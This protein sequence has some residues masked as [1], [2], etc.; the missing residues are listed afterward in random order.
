[1]SLFQYQGF[2]MPMW[3]YRNASEVS[4][5]VSKMLATNSNAGIIDFHL[6]TTGQTGN[7]V[8][9][10][11]DNTLAQLDTAIKAAKS[12]GLDVWFKPIVIMGTGAD[13]NSWQTLAPTDPA[14]WFRTYTAKLVEIGKVLQADGVSHFLLTNEL[15]SMTTNPAYAGYWGALITEVRSVF[16]GKIG[17]NAGALLGPWAGGNEYL[18]IPK[19]V[20]AQV[21]FMGLSSYPRVQA[22]GPFTTDSVTKGWS[23][24]AY[25]ENLLQQ[26]SQYLAKEKLPVYFTELGSSAYASGNYDYGK[27]F[28]VDLQSQANFY[29]AT[30]ALLEKH[31]PNKISGVFVYNWLMNMT[32]G[33]SS[34]N[35]YS[36]YD[37]NVIN[38]P[39]E[40]AITK[41]FGSS[42]I[43]SSKGYWIE[44]LSV[45]ESID[46]SSGTDTVIFSSNKPLSAITT[47]LG[48]TQVINGAATYTLTNIERI[49]FSDTMLALDTGAN[50]IA[51]SGYMLYKAA[52]N[53]TPDAG[54]LGYWINQMDKGMVYGDVA[55]NFVNST[56]FKTAFGGNN[57]TVNTLVTKLYNNVLNRTPDAGGLA[58]WQNKL[59]NEGWTTADVLGFFSTSGEN[60]TNV[61]PLIANG[62]QYQQFVG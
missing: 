38:K 9:Y 10:R 59:S 31:F 32:Q 3:S 60:V 16:Q 18:G 53:R 34:T 17:F 54:G 12:Q 46:G 23:N 51:G 43:N 41:V 45:S 47:S 50:Q 48:S 57:P 49:K 52:F 37:W 1:M 55:K 4:L 5:S 29:S 2:T 24:S 56:E 61:T 8:D 44:A 30:I 22:N 33:Q 25:G 28:T 27:N 6:A 58:F 36:S 35:N 42:T 7:V 20:L 19:E 15:Q 26:L 11:G 40:A 62:I 39:S 13:Q 14:Q 21:D